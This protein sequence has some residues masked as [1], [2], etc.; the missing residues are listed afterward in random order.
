MKEFQ[1]S[2]KEKV[3]RLSPNVKS[4]LENML[5]T[6]TMNPNL[7][8]N[9]KDMH[10]ELLERMHQGELREEELPKVSTIA[11]WIKKTSA[12]WKKKMAEETL[13]S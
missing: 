7:K 8:M 3:K 2:Q 13:Y 12:V 6:G 4:L 9:A 1:K 5:H 10:E 11:N